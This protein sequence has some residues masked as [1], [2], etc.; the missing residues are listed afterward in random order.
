LLRSW[1]RAS[2]QAVLEFCGKCPEIHRRESSVVQ[3]VAFSGFSKL[4]LFEFVK[5]KDTKIK[6]RFEMP[7]F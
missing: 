7:L 1:E 5:P 2:F 4:L 3:N 6:I